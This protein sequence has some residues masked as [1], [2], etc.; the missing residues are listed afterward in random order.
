LGRC[1]TN[2]WTGATGSDFRIKRDPAKLLGSAVARST[3]PLCVRT[4]VKVG[5]CKPIL[6]AFAVWLL[7]HATDSYA[8]SNVG[9]D[10]ADT[11]VGELRIVQVNDKETEIKLGHRV[12]LRTVKRTLSRMYDLYDLSIYDVIRH[13]IPPFAQVVILNNWHGNHTGCGPGV[14]FLGLRKDGKYRFSKST[15]NC[16]DRKIE[17]TKDRIVIK[18]V[19]D[20]STTLDSYFP[21]PGG[22]WVYRNGALHTVKLVIIPDTRRPIR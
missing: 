22:Q 1:R 8:Q 2:R 13:P 3:P 21:I 9:T 18:A 14:L 7:F 17:V 12:I 15:P 4:V 10:R 11:I 16:I 20:I 5:E 19:P 6:L